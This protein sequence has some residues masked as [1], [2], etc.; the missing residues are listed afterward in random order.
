MQLDQAVELS[1]PFDPA[2]LQWSSPREG[3]AGIVH[4]ASPSHW[5]KVD[6]CARHTMIVYAPGLSIMRPFLLNDYVGVVPVSGN[7]RAIQL[8][9]FDRSCVNLDAAIVSDEEQYQTII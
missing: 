2:A 8:S 7:E 9:I 3:F 6:G 5:S 1:P 4:V